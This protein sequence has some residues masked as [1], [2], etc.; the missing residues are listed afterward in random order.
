[1]AV[2]FWLAFPAGLRAAGFSASLDRD[3]ISMG[4]SATLTLAFDGGSP[5]ALPPL[6][7]IPGLNIRDGGGD[8]TSIS[9][10]NGE[11][12]STASHNFLVVP[13]KDGT[14]VIPPMSVKI[15]GQICRSQPVKLTVAKAAAASPNSNGNPK[16]VFLKLLAPKTDVYVGEIFP[17][18]IQLYFHTAQGGDM[19]HL[20][21]E[22]FTLGKMIQAPESSTV[23]AGQQLNV[24]TIKTY[25]VPA[26]AG[27]LDLGPATMS[28]KIPTGYQRDWFGRLMATGW[29]PVTLQSDPLPLQVL[30]V[31]KDNAPASFSGAVGNYSMM[32]T[33]SPTNIAIGDPLT[34]KIQII[35]QGDLSG[36]T[37]PAQT[38]WQ[39]FKLYPPTSDF[40]PAQDDA[41]G[42]SGTRTFSLTAVPQTMDIKELP[43][44]TFSFFDPEQR[45]FRTLTQASVPLIV[46][47][48][49][50]SLPPSNLANLN[51]SADNS[52]TSEDIKPIKQRPGALAEIQPPLIERPV[53]LALQSVPAL[54]WL[55]LL[56]KR[57]QDERL[58]NNPRLRRQ[59]LT[60]RIVNE[61]MRKLR[62][63][64]QANQGKEFFATVFHLLQER[65]GERLD[66]PASAITEAVLDERLRPLNAPEE[67]VGQLRELFHVCNQARYAPQTTHEELASL[68]PKVESALNELK[69]LKT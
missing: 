8:A 48:S 64:A 61:G 42:I 9:I 46:R 51:S 21:E 36:I 53:F 67:L 12:S 33:A 68:V 3:A 35:G 4:E 37:L 39:Q 69:R 66:L 58:A 23:V 15:G 17:V 62:Q 22:G 31:P 60:E 55:T 24:V 49:A 40:Q 28:L 11:V 2:C 63:S 6:P 44:F 10:V 13:S 18:E 14:F 38:N 1:M 7:N 57:K 19:P 34:V 50:A 27:K 59:R 25:A 43:P 29:Q 16:S 26:K 20:N 47:P 52:T 30:P 54:A 5:D 56:V 32:L 41:L 45:E 65:L